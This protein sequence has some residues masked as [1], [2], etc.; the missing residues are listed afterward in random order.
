MSSERKSSNCICDALF[1]LKLFQDF[2]KHSHT[3]FYGHLLAEIVNTDT[4]P[5]FLITKKGDP[6]SFND[7]KECFETSYFRIESVD[8]EKCCTTISLLRPLDIEGRISNSICDV[9]RLEKTSTC[10]EV[11]LTCICAIQLLDTELLRRKIIIEP[12]W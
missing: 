2:L 11:D 7:T 5:F 10:K 3:K 9:V 12:K 1:E 4:I 8:P 6:L